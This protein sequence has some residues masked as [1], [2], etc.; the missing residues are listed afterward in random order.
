[1]RVAL[2]SMTQQSE[3]ADGGYRA[4]AEFAGRSVAMRQLEL[5]LA[6]GCERIVCLAD[7]LHQPML[8][9]QHRCESAG[10]RFHV[11][12]GPRPVV[13]LVRAAD[14]LLVLADGLLPLEDGALERL[15]GQGGIL[16]LPADAGMAA[17]FERVDLNY[18]WAG[19][20]TMPGRLVER[21]AELPADCDAVG[22]LLRIALQARLP[23]IPLSDTVLAEGRWPLIASQEQAAALE[24][25]WLR[26]QLPPT[27]S[28][29]PFRLLSG[30]LLAHFGVPLLRRGKGGGALRFL[31]P[32]LAV[33][34][35]GL[36]VA[37][38]APAGFVL[39]A[40]SF[41]AGELAAGLRRLEQPAGPPSGF[42]LFQTAQSWVLD[43]CLAAIIA[44]EVQMDDGWRNGIFI[45]AALL[46]LLR[47]LALLLEARWAAV[48]SD[49]GLLATL[50]AA[51]AMAGA[52][53]PA[54]Q[55]IMLIGLA[56]GVA[57]QHF[58]QR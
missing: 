47:L 58:R 38:S 8:P 13:G 29:A 32:F 2:L 57:F 46:A 20:A 53:L 7:H 17:G 28:F 19:A 42:S 35:A 6:F 31:A 16:V 4:F 43:A 55:A 37:Y 12:T 56:S 15:S 30:I 41:V 52:L 5:A 3:T 39:A 49:R 24:A 14:Q 54:I 36:G 26:R 27:D 10:A 18:A 34:A 51:G 50:L 9:L 21:L 45:A 33:A 1:M 22:A 11:V 48:A 44:H 23:E 25:P 40:L